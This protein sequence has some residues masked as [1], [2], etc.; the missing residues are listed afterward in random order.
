MLYPAGTFMH[1]ED[2]GA[3]APTVPYSP[4]ADAPYSPPSAPS[5]GLTPAA[6]APTPTTAISSGAARRITPA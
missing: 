1:D 6:P 5:A 2:L 4:P 3:T